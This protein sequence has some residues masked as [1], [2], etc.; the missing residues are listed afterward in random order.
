MSAKKTDVIKNSFTTITVIF[1]ASLILIILAFANIRGLSTQEKVEYGFK[2]LTSTTAVYIGLGI[3]LNAYYS[4]KR[5]EEVINNTIEIQKNTEVGLKNLQLN[6]ERLLAQRFLGAI[7]QLGNEKIE[8]RTGAIYVLER[9]AQDSPKEHWTIMEILTAFVR[10]NS[11]VTQQEDQTEE[12]FICE[13]AQSS[14]LL[15]ELPKIRTDIQA[16]LTTIA[17][18]NIDQDP[19]NQ[20]LD[21]SSTDIRWA[22]LQGAKLRGVDLRFANLSGADLRDADLSGAELE[23]AKFVDTI[24]YEVNFH[25]A[26]LRGANL[27]NA[28]LHKATLSETNLRFSNLSSTNLSGAN[29]VGANLYKASLQAANL[30]VANLKNAKL[31]LANLQGAKLVKA[32]LQETGLIGANLQQANLNGANLVG[33]NLNAAKLQQAEVQFANL[34]NASLTEAD[35]RLANFTGSNLSGA[36][37][38]EANLCGASFM[39]VDLCGTN[40]CDVKLEGTI[41][42]G[43]KNLQ[44]QQIK[45][46]IGDRTTRL[47]ENIETPTHW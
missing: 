41:L 43:V 36:I 18:R 31:Y 34:C 28:S 27:K 14:S 6:R 17:R 29:L 25:A 46:A 1:T 16:A 42:T 37:L 13:E 23:C 21:L 20:K 9:V 12:S 47:P 45:F 35:L 38:Q 40:L 22:D 11:P 2:T 30:K 4:A 24:L 44:P 5:A 8:V 15:G 39:G 7:E 33:V 26:N 3:M 19:E 32:N 10:E